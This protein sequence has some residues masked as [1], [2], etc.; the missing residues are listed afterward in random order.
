MKKYIEIAKV[1]FRA[2]LV[3]RFD[4]ALTAVGTAF[5]IIFAV[6]LWG[7]VYEGRTDVAGFSYQ[8]M[9]SYYIVTSLLRSFDLT[10][11][12]LSEVS[13]R[14]R[15]G[16]FTRFMTIPSN[17]LS[18]FMAQTLGAAAFHALFGLAAVVLSMI[19]FGINL[20]PVQSPA[21]ILCAVIMVA[22]GQMFMMGYQFTLGLLAF[23]LGDIGLLR[24]VQGALLEFATG[25]IVPLIMLPLWAQGAL[26]FLPFPHA[27]YTPAMLLTG[28]IGAAQAAGPMLILSAWTIAM[29]L[30][31]NSTYNRLRVQYDGVGV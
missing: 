24:H 7:A 10:D 30:I 3:Y 15:N 13:D 14:I 18:Y 23:K 20:T 26:G 12:V 1:L 27:L 11:G 8:A 28:Q 4:V 16:T 6:I 17:P 9:L 19:V 21:A 2:Q 5:R 22:L 31:A 25:G 29:I